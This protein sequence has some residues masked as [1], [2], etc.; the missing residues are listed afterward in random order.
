MTNERAE[1]DR[2]IRTSVTAFRA[3]GDVGR[4]M[5]RD[6]R[7]RPGAAALDVVR[8]LLGVALF[9]R[10][11]FF[12]QDTDK[13]F[14][15]FE[16]QTGWFGASAIAHYVALFHLAGGLLLVFG[17]RTRIAAAVQLPALVAAFA[18]EGWRGGLLDVTGS[19]GSPRSRS[20]CWSCSPSSGAARGPR[21]RS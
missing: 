21:R 12:L 6:A 16:A 17:V 9:V 2:T 19:S 7:D 13:L 11:A 5:A 15:I 14:A 8:A 4:T 1:E 10:G 20:R 3:V 18:F